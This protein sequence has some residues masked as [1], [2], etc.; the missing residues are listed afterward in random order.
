MIKGF[1][2]V[3]VLVGLITF[4]HAIIPH[5]HHADFK[6]H[7]THQH[8]TNGLN[9]I[10]FLQLAFHNTQSFGATDTFTADNNLKQRIVAEESLLIKWLREKELFVY[11]YKS[12]SEQFL[13]TQFTGF[14]EELRGPPSFLA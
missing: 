1:K 9:F 6:E 4:L 12:Y 2:I 8:D 5:D 10:D 11:Y 7:E 3:L 14:T 13:F